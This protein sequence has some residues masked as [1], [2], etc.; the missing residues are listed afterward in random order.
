MLVALETTWQDIRYAVRGLM[1]NPAFSLTAILAAALG[2]GAS[3]AVFS[4][5]D[6][7]LFRP[8]P[9]LNEERLVSAGM[10]APLD[11]NEFLFAEPYFTLRRYP[12]PFEAVTAFQA[13]T[14]ATDLTEGNPVRLRALRV[15]S[16]F[17]D[18]FG[19]PP[20]SGRG[21]TREE[22]LPN[23]PHVAVISHGLWLSRF[24]GDPRAVG[25]TLR[26]DGVPLEIVGVLPKDF[27]MPTLTEADVLLPLALDESRER[28]GRALRVFGRLKPSVSVR[29]AIDQLQPQ[30]QLALQTVPERF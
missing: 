24:A 9:Y 1:R 10:M 27:R 30:F 6:R 16:N 17:L 11:T 25:R 4:A 28:S 18:M 15:E 21:F 7:I 5:V 20:V 13:G 23:G 8:L 3:S 14:I 26:L 22:D 12:G 29:Q 2:I 19:I